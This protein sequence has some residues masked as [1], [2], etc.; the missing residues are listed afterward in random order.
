MN[1]ENSTSALETG[2]S[3]SVNY[4]EKIDDKRREALSPKSLNICH[5]ETQLRRDVK[6]P[7]KSV[8]PRP[9]LKML[10]EKPPKS[11]KVVPEMTKDRRRE[12]SNSRGFVRSSSTS[13]LQRL[14]G[15]RAC[16]SDDA[17]SVGSVMSSKSTQST[18]RVRARS[19][20][21]DRS[22]ANVPGVGKGIKKKSRIRSAPSTPTGERNQSR[23]KKRTKAVSSGKPWERFRTNS[24]WTEQQRK[25]QADRKK[26]STYDS[27]SGERDDLVLEELQKS[28]TR[29]TQTGVSNKRPRALKAVQGSKNESEATDEG[30]SQNVSL[31]SK[32]P[33]STFRKV[34]AGLRVYSPKKSTLQTPKPTKSGNSTPLSYSKVVKLGST[35]QFI[36]KLFDEKNKNVLEELDRFE[37][38]NLQHLSLELF[39]EG[40]GISDEEIRKI[41]NAR[42]TKADKWELKTQVKD[43]NHALK[44]LKATTN[45]LMKGKNSFVKSAIGS[46]I[47]ATT[48]FNRAV[49]V[50]REFEVERRTMKERLVELESENIGLKDDHKDKDRELGVKEN[51]SQYFQTEI[52][53]LKAQ[54]NESQKMHTQ[55]SI[56]LEVEKAQRQE[57]AKTAER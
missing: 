54:L 17:S 24:S 31:T 23:L 50:A 37:S 4:K 55:I 35:P 14:S 19:A 27:R 7:L 30:T 16:D 10:S 48:G 29:L 11:N 52:D 20:S 26:R 34:A 41:L 33:I 53:T 45:S 18:P 13:S 21:R 39:G 56:A 44:V 57:A 28:H 2:N 49:E 47:T 32:S 3:K 22:K 25:A 43:T 15:I 51:K 46:M 42:P 36:R 40:T 1:D 38:D 9:P 5:D 6:E 12:R 8:P